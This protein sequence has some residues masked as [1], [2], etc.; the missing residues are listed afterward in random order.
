MP[1]PC[2]DARLVH[3]N[4]TLVKVFNKIMPRPVPDGRK[5]GLYGLT[6]ERK[7][8]QTL[9]KNGGVDLRMTSELNIELNEIRRKRRSTEQANIVK[10][11][12]RDPSDVFKFVNKLKGR[13]PGCPD[14]LVVGE[15]TLYDKAA[16][17]E[18]IHHYDRLGKFTHPLYNEDSQMN[19]DSIKVVTRIVNMVML[20][21]KVKEDKIPPVDL[22]EFKEIIKSF[23][24]GKASDI[25]G[26]S[27]DMYRHLSDENLEIIMEWINDLFSKDDFYSPELSRSRFSL[28]FK[29][30]TFVSLGNYRRLTVSSVMLR[31]LERILMRRG[32]GD[33]IG[34]SLE[35]AQM[36]FRKYRCYQ[37]ALLE[38]TELM[39]RFKTE[40]SPLFILSTDVA[41]AFP[42]QDPRINLLEMI[43]RG[44]SGGELKFSRDTY[45]GRRSHL[46][47]NDEVYTKPNVADEYGETEG[48]TTCP[49]RA[50]ANF[51]IICKAINKS[52]YGVT[53]KGIVTSGILDDNRCVLEET[54]KRVPVRMMADDALYSLYTMY[55]SAA[56]Y[57]S[58]LAESKHTRCHYNE[59]KCYL[60]ALNVDFEEAE[61]EW[62]KI[63]EKENITLK[64]TNKLKY[65]GMTL[66]G[67]DEYDVQNVKMKIGGANGSLRII[68]GAGLNQQKLCSPKLR[69]S[70]VHSF[71][72][73]KC[74]SGLD[75]MRLSSAAEEQLRLYGEVLMRKTFFL[76]RNA[77]THLV[78]LIAGKI[79]LNAYWRLSQINLLIRILGLN[80]QLAA[81]LRWDFIHETRGSWVYQA[82]TILDHYGIKDYSRLFL[83]NVVTTKNARAI[84]LAIK[85]HVVRQ[86]FEY[87]KKKHLG[88]KWSNNFDLSSLRPGKPSR[89]I[90]DASTVQE[91][92]GVSTII[93]HLTNTYA[94]NTLVDRNATCVVCKRE[95]V[96]DTPSHLWVCEKA[97]IARALRCE[98]QEE[99]PLGHPAKGLHVTS[100][101][102]TK[103][104]LDP[105]SILLEEYQLQERPENFM[106]I[107]SLCRLIAHF[108]HQNRYRIA[109]KLK[110]ADLWKSKGKTN[111]P[112]R[113]KTKRPISFL[114]I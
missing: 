49:L 68:S 110:K 19:P 9:K 108:S 30:G 23:K 45:L 93:Q 24:T 95:G 58:I 64:L 96:R 98:L 76:H 72:V 10:N 15:R 86:E 107:Q 48:G 65:L 79:R 57:K 53:Q 21:K 31:I 81:A 18:I 59:S 28:L 100:G 87:L 17:E 102:L 37:M 67:D 63:Q 105:E 56:C 27:H 84:Y 104:I 14:K 43:K 32:M 39:R 6:R 16:H 36:G 83:G 77:S 97:T 101:T 25:S 73:S 22:K 106:R 80:T 11:Y 88:Q 42:R 114:E 89:H 92:R 85:E 35:D 46:K 113:E 82:V 12:N 61:K 41:K 2:S 4:D 44:L 60:L 40:N 94:T 20:S 69:V 74:L 112:E 75:G 50:S 71:V 1:K 103:F 54:E 7:I 8:L 55:M 78:H 51:D 111:E 33:K 47:V 3:I 26:V 91:I 5:R 70:M 99:L 34:A 90:L 29:A 109:K 62:K 66:S 38:I 13:G 52:A